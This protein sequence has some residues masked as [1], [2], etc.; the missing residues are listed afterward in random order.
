MTYANHRRSL[1]ALAAGFLFA[2]GLAVAGMT[3]PGK[4]V[5]FLDFSGNW[6]P[7]LMF[8]MGAGVVVYLPAYQLITKRKA[9]LFGGG[10]SLP[11]R[12]DIDAPL[13]LGAALF[14]FGWGLG[15]FCPGPALTSVGALA[16]SALV[17]SA[18]MLLGFGLKRGFDALRTRKRKRRS[19]QP[20]VSELPA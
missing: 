20:E 9:P 12:R 6:D 18:A 11:S 10:F 3:Q 2:V 7:S 14:G 13:V 5:G 16:P 17:F 8:V 19:A 15:G 1:L 4:V